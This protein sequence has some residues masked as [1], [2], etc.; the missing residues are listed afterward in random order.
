MALEPMPPPWTDAFLQAYATD[1]RVTGFLLEHIDDEAWKAKPPAGRSIAAIVAHMHNVRVM[2]ARQ[3]AR[4]P[5][6]EVGP[7]DHESGGRMSV[8]F[9]TEVRR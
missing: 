1:D 2:L 8:D 7:V 9:V 3:L 4:G 6:R 5:A